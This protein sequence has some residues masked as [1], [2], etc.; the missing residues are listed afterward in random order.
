MDR[1]AESEEDGPVRS[2]NEPRRRG[3]VDFPVETL[4]PFAVGRRR[5]G[6]RPQARDGLGCCVDEN[7]PDA[8]S[9]VGRLLHPYDHLPYA[10]DEPVET[11]RDLPDLVVR[12]H[13]EP[14]RE[15][16][17]RSGDRVEIGKKR[18]KGFH[19]EDAHKEVRRH[20][21]TDQDCRDETSR[22]ETPTITMI[23]ALTPNLFICSLRLRRQFSAIHPLGIQ[24]HIQL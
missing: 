18:T 4:N 3:V 13:R 22:N 1:L 11:H 2:E 10:L 7:R 16:R 8:P 14:G 21:Q 12:L 6:Y 23:F 24:L 15:V 9:R 5:I 17:F 19:D 20:D